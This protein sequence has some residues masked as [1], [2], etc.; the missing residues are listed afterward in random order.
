MSMQIRWIGWLV[1]VFFLAAVLPIES[2]AGGQALTPAAL[3]L[4]PERTSPLDL[5]VSGELA[6]ISPD[7]V[8]YLTRDD[9]LALPQVTFTV[10]NDAN[11]NGPTQVSGV[12][13]EEL[14]RQLGSTPKSDMVVAICDDQYR[15]NYPPAY[16]AAHQP[17][18]VLKVNGQPPAA[19]PKDVEGHGQNMG[20]YMISHRKFLPNFKVSAYGD[21]AQIPWG[22]VRLEFRDEK[23][24]YGVITPRGPNA[25]NEAVQHG[26]WIARQNCFRCHNNG[27]EGGTK[28]DR[29]WLVLSA[30]A[31]ASPEY[32]A[33]YV[34]NPQS[35]NPHAQMPGNPGY[36]QK[37]IDALTAYFQTFS[38]QQ[39]P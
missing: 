29:P 2:A 23:T 16:I 25:A 20:P 9:L 7:S 4:R 39:K 21:E 37:I 24:V 5:E 26:Y 8:R 27:K 6:G 33:A 10:K 18:L 30:W 31:T 17:L 28:A 32:F 1:A 15:A 35:K 13:L 19:W 34:R 11:F 3:T 38:S 12:L 36:N 14:I 22:V